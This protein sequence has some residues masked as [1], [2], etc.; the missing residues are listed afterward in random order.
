MF[1]LLFAIFLAVVLVAGIFFIVKPIKVVD[2][3]DESES[4][5]AS[6]VVGGIVAVIAAVF[7]AIM[8][9]TSVGATEVGVPVTLGKPGAP[10]GP[11]PH[12]VLPW[13]N[14]KTLDVKTQ[15]ISLDD[16]ATVK[17]IT[18]DRISVPVDVTVYFRVDS[19]KAPTLL[20]TVGEDYVDKIVTPVTR[21]VI[22]D[23][24]S[25]FNSE[26]IQTLR[27]D[28]E[29]AIEESLAK[30]LAARG[31][32]LEKVELRKLQVPDEILANAQAKINADE[33]QKRAKIDAETARIEAEGKARANKIVADSLE[34]NP[35]I[36][37]S[38]FVD[39]LR[40]G[41]IKPPIYVNPCGGSSNGPNLLIQPPAG[42]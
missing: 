23:Q 16:D 39:G 9:V 40:N 27:D 30:P 1:S 32:I 29:R 20:L 42:Q 21:S 12:A 38:N 19:E 7:L 5:I 28:Y 4:T 14:V 8:S 13:T 18:S 36:I 24:G 22:Y 15:A 2:S 6:R 35:A 33:L 17:T 10:L 31:V 41:T 3:Y 25:K 37:C 11:G 34:R 26:N